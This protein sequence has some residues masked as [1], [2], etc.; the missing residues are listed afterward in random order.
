MK[1]LKLLSCYGKNIAYIYIMNQLIWSIQFDGTNTALL[2]RDPNNYRAW[3]CCQLSQLVLRSCAYVLLLSSIY[4]RMSNFVN[5]P[6][7]FVILI[8]LQV[9]Q[10]T[11]CFDL[12][13]KDVLCARDAIFHPWTLDQGIC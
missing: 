9:H 13:F 2:D 5:H 10:D 3:S 7:P 4:P 8:D 1:L 12:S 11:H 6:H